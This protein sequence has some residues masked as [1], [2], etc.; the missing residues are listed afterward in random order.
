MK[1][2]PNPIPL[3][4]F[5]AAAAVA[6]AAMF[7]AAVPEAKAQY[8][9]TTLNLNTAV[10]YENFNSFRGSA[11]TLP[12]TGN[13]NVNSS[14]GLSYQGVSNGNSGTGGVYAY[15]VDNTDRS[16]GFLGSG[17][18]GQNMNATAQ[19]QN[20]SGATITSFVLSFTGEEWRRVSGSTSQITVFYGTTLAGTTTALGTS[21]WSP[22]NGATANGSLLSSATITA[23]NTSF[24]IANGANIF[25]RFAYLGGGGT[26]EG[27]SFDDLTIRFN[28]TVPAS[29][30]LYW[31]A[32]GTT[33]GGT[34]NWTTAGSNWSPTASPVDEAAWIASKTAI[35]AGTA[36]TVTVQGGG[37]TAS[38]GLVFS[39][40]GYEITGGDLTLGGTAIASN[41]ITTDTSVTATISSK[42]SG[43]N[44]M[45]KAGA[46]NLV[47]SG[48]NDYGGGT[49]VSG[50]RL[51]GTTTSLQG[52]ITNNAAVTFDQT[53]SGTYSSAM[54][55]SGSLRK[56]GSGTITLGG[57]NTYSGGTEVAAGGL[58]GTTTSLQ[59]AITNNGTVGFE[60]NTDG[61][62]NGAMTGS[63]SL[64]KTG[65][66]TVTLGGANTYSGGTLVS[67]GGLVG[68]TTSLQGAITNNATVTFDQGT[69]GTYAGELSGSGELVKAGG[70]A[71]T[72]SGDN[73]YAG[74]TSIDGGSIV[75][76]HDNALGSGDVALGAT[77]K[78]FAADGIT[79]GNAIT[80]AQGFAILYEQDFNSIDAG[81]PTGWTVRT[82]ATSSTLGT[83]GSFTTTEIDWAATGGAF[84]NFASAT[85]LTSSSTI[86]QQEASTDRALGI[87]QTS[88]FGD[89]GAAF[90]YAFSTT[91]ET[92]D[93]ISLD[94]MMLSVQGRSTTWS[95]EYGIGSAPTS[96]TSLGT[97]ADPGTFGTTPFTITSGTFGT[98]LDNQSD[99]IFR[100]V[101]LTAATGAN[102]R[103]SMGLDNFV[104]G[105]GA[106]G[107]AALA[108]T[109]GS[110]VVNGTATFSGLVTLDGTARLTAASG[111][112]VTFSGDLAGAGGIRKIG[113]GTVTLS[114]ATDNTFTGTTTV[115]A[116]TLALAKTAGTD[117]IAGNVAVL[118]GATLLVAADNQV[119]DTG[120]V[121]LSGGTIALGDGTTETFGDLTVSSASVLDFGNGT[122]Y[123]MSFGTYAP[124]SLLTINNFI[125]FSTLTF[126]SDLT[127]TIN[128]PGLFAFSNG[129]SSALWDS[130][131][132]TFTITAIPE[133]STYVAAAGL[134]GLMLWPVRRRLL[135][136]AKSILGLRAP[137]RDRLTRKA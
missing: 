25:F 11:A 129:F 62:Y 45:T 67:A 21:T 118:T 105:G 136:D 63:G 87:R 75:A 137:M 52:T 39:N 80:V 125:G 56:S 9:I 131:T 19:F 26:R 88:G 134:L 32:D 112:N 68:T 8:L 117:A 99:V 38:A 34:G 113:V 97:W 42:I 29:D 31:T 77:S 1:T 66:G 72:M 16:F 64:A 127:S 49:I 23:D 119:A 74:G 109:I 114:G 48:A 126:G 86:A 98:A 50:G 79:V 111:A 128:D 93:S 54:S 132:S 41:T 2:Y 40:T 7:F 15:G 101:A 121:T 94:L 106:S 92:V 100:V 90:T 14:N 85:G 17:A 84:K 51:V 123:N 20:T 10:T 27:L 18:A 53:T 82:G 46:G 65:T 116:G 102:N 6:L 104:I 130:G 58:I 103:D 28:G 95:I 89:P 55:G 70:G 30:N 120:T 5:G 135:R 36:G 44:G 69:T 71:V 47:L 12:S 43:A 81:L 3:S 33:L 35:F 37:I 76:A 83:S 133:P 115:A 60:Q 61:S 13:W 96:F 124:T 22:V 73:S 57:A 24:N 107:P 78:L 110:D 122:G 91:G 108:G 4:R 59:G